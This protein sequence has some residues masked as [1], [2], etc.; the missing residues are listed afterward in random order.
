MWVLAFP[1]T[2]APR[3]RDPRPAAPP[4]R[5]LRAPRRW[6]DLRPDGGLTTDVI[7]GF[8]GE[9]RA[10]GEE[11]LQLVR[12]ANFSSVHV[13]PYS[14]REGAFAAENLDVLGGLIS[15]HEQACRV[16]ELLALGRE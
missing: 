12:D 14:P 7:V 4:E 8:P 10:E 16:D 5:F 2:P 6:R 13:F 9:T 15:P 11:S 3:G 1:A